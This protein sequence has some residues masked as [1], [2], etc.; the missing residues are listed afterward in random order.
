MAEKFFNLETFL[1]AYMDLAKDPGWK[2]AFT[3]EKRLFWERAMDVYL[4]GNQNDMTEE[5]FLMKYKNIMPKSSWE[6]IEMMKAARNNPDAQQD[7]KNTV[8]FVTEQVFNPVNN[9]QQ[10]DNLVYLQMF[11]N[12]LKKMQDQDLVYEAV[13]LLRICFNDYKRPCAY[14]YSNTNLDYKPLFHDIVIMLASNPNAKLEDLSELIYWVENPEQA[15][16]VINDIFAKTDEMLNKEMSKDI[17]DSNSVKNSVCVPGNVIDVMRRGETTNPDYN[18]SLVSLPD[19]ERDV[20]YAKIQRWAELAKDKY[21]FDKVIGSGDQEYV[22]TYGDTLEKKNID[23]S[24]QNAEVMDENTKLKA[25]NRRI[26]DSINEKNEEIDRLKNEIARLYQD[27]QNER[28]AKTKA[29][30]RIRRFSEAA[31]A[32]EQ[33]GM[34]KRSE[35]LKKLQAV[36]NDANSI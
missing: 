33:A 17:P 20:F 23:L 35:A 27:L 36:N 19:K 30:E 1:R 26:N 15:E 32:V 2:G 5:Y 29:Q 7:I 24:K 4:F 8:R 6:I 21:N 34:L 14:K 16:K 9:N 31:T 22:T 10:Y 11:L 18:N 28:S 13:S 3:S 25:A 12:R